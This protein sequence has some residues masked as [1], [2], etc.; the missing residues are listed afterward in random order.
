M[1][2]NIYG[3]GATTILKGLAFE[4]ETSLAHAFQNQGFQVANNVLEKN[5]TIYGIVTSKYGLHKY[6]HFV[7]CKYYFNVILL[8]DS[9]I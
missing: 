9:S 2:V 4:Q 1:P 7:N 3:G 6:I 8:T 5:G